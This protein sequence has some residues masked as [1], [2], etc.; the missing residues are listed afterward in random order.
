VRPIANAALKR[1]GGHAFVRFDLGAEPI[2]WRL[3]RRARQTVLRLF[4]V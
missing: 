4:D 3:L 1:I 2:A